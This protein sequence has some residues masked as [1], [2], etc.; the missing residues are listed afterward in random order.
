MICISDAGASRFHFASAEGVVTVY[1]EGHEVIRSTKPAHM[2]LLAQDCLNGLLRVDVD[3]E[4]VQIVDHRWLL[5][6]AA[7]CC[8]IAARRY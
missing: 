8:L 5:L 4:P 3:G 7:E 2:V 1:H 6:L